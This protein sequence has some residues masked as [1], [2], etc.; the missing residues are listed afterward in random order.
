VDQLPVVARDSD[1]REGGRK[2]FGAGRIDLVKDEAGTGAVREGGKEAGAGRRLQNQIRGGDS[3]SERSEVGDRGGGRELLKLDLLL[4][5]GGMRGQAGDELGQCS[6]AIARGGR[7]VG[8]RQVH[9]LGEFEHVVSVAKRPA[10]VGR[11]SAIG[12]LH[13]P[14]Q[15]VAL[16]RSLSSDGVGDR[17]GGRDRR[18]GEIEFE[19]CG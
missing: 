11:G 7:Q 10:T 5:A 18:F 16:Q 13:D 3:A 15:R 19:S 12:L 14:Q 17:L 4:A 8:L 2:H 6:K 9:D 1:A